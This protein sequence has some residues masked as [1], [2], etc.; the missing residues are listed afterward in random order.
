MYDD[1]A[2]ENMTAYKNNL[3]IQAYKYFTASVV[4]LNTAF[5]PLSQKST[6]KFM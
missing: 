1:C 4:Y 3:Q 2:D 5:N 6:A